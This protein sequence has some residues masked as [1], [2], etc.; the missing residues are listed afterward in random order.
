M[1]KDKVK[2]RNDKRKKIK[3]RI[4]R[5]ISGDSERPRL[6]VYKSRRYIYAQ[7]INDNKQ[8]TIASASSIEKDI[9]GNKRCVKDIETAKKIGELIA[10][11]LKKKGV[12]KAVFD[13]NGYL[14][15]GK[16]KAVADGAREKGLK[17]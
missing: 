3:K 4:R 6:V 7:A 8:I 16:V 2:K 11:R 1:I 9:R 13:R 5:K 14:F 10:E 17:L 12:K 15:H